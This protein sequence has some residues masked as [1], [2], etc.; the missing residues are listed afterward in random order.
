MGTE[1][2]KTLL[3][4]LNKGEE[5]A[6]ITKYNL[7]TK[8]VE[9]NIYNLEELEGKNLEYVNKA[10]EKNLIANI[11]INDEES[12]LAEVFK[13]EHRLIVFGAGH[14]GYHLCH[15][16]SKVGFNTIVVDD[17]PYFA[18]KEKFGDD[19][20]VICN[21]FENAFEILDIHEEDY[22][23]IV[24]RGHKHD[25]FCLEKIL[26]LDELNYIGMIG[27]KR[28]VKIMKE[29]LIEEGYSKEKIENI[30]SPIGL[31]IGAVTPEEIA[32][33]ILAEIISVKR[34][35]KLAVKNEPIKVS[36]SCELNKDVLEALAKSQNEKMSLVTVISTKGSTPRKAGSKMIVYDSGKIIGTIG[37][38]CAEAKI[39]KDAALMAG[40][41]NLKIET[42][43]MTGEIAEEEGMVCGGK[44]TVLIEAI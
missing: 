8:K 15:F 37:G 10:K 12:V 5:V 24:T 29:E 6:L 32:I 13:R 38:G 27:S 43:D 26:S 28:R 39:I 41:K 34:I 7:E 23:V 36:N 18:N 22:V 16:A 2:Y 40:S 3:E 1:I 42:I 19:I 44:M 25:K 30:Y 20:Q 31:N 33:S 17:R 35:G 21:T 11:K 9:K 4:D 14:V